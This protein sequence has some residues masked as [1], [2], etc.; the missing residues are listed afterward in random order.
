MKSLVL[1][2]VTEKIFV[3]KSYE[4]VNDC[5]TFFSCVVSDAIYNRFLSKWK[6]SENM[7]FLLVM[8]KICSE[9]STVE[10]YIACYYN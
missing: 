7:L 1:N 6:Y 4:V 8:N 9:L 10:Q 5:L 3:T 2:G